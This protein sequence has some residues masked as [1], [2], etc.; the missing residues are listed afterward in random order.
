MSQPPEPPEPH[1]GD[2][3]PVVPASPVMSFPQPAPSCLPGPEPLR[4]RT[5]LIRSA[6]VVAGVLVLGGLLGVVW[7]RLAPDV[8]VLVTEAGPIFGHPQPEQLV[9]AEGWFALLS[10][11]V[12]VLAA[13]G[14]WLVRSLR[15]VTGLTAATLGA[16]GAGLLAWWVGRHLG[17]ADYQQALADAAV[18]TELERPQDLRVAQLDWWPPRLLGLPLVPAFVCAITYTVLAV[19]SPDPSLRRRRSQTSDWLPHPGA[20]SPA[21][22]PPRSHDLDGP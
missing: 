20:E 8:P 15:G 13:V 4:W 18:G 12:G 21:G 5:R 6:A 2:W 22:V 16:V 1:H 3:R 11:P 19:W 9:A 14:A 7:A 17:L 10:L